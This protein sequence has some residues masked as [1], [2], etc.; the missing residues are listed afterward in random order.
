MCDGFSRWCEKLS[1]Q[2]SEITR[3]TKCIS[4]VS[5]DVSSFTCLTEGF[6]F[7]CLCW[8]VRRE[9]LCCF[10]LSITTVK[11]AWFLPVSGLLNADSCPWCFLQVRCGGTNFLYLSQLGV[12]RWEVFC[13]SKIIGTACGTNRVKSAQPTISYDA[14]TAFSATAT[15]LRQVGFLKSRQQVSVVPCAPAVVQMS[16]TY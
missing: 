2:T 14:I 13:L 16:C 7:S 6:Q 9:W 3:N 11:P 15:A 8:E 5:I 12:E 1:P 4:A 10:S